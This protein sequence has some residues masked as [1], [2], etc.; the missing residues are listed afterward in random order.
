MVKNQKFGQKSK[1]WSKMTNLV[2]NQK[3]GQKYK[4]NRK[5]TINC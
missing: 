4:K 5:K 1:I 2:K 3:F